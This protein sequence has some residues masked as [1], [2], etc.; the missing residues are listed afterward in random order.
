[1]NESIGPYRI[2]HPLGE[3]GMGIVYAAHDDRLDRTV[4]LKL[5]TLAAG[6][7]GRE[8]FRREAKVAAKVNHPNICQVYDV[9]EHEGQPFLAME[10]LSGQSLERRILT[11]PI[12]PLEALPLFR[13]ILQGL[14]A[15]HDAGIIH[16]DLK[17]SNVFLTAN[18]VKLLDFGLAR[19]IEIEESSL[20]KPGIVVG[21]PRYMA[22]EQWSA[23]ATGP[24]SDIFAASAIFFEMLSGR[25]AFG[26]D[27]PLA[28]AKAIATEHPP[29]LTGDPTIE[30]LD[31]VIH[32]GLSKEMADRYLS[33]PAMMAALEAASI[34][35]DE[36]LL[37]PAQVRAV[38]RLSVLPFRLLRPDEEIDF[39]SFSLADA[40]ISSLSGMRS[41]VVRSS[42][43]APGV[44][45]D[46]RPD[47]E[48]LAA[49]GD[50]DAVLYGTLLRN[51]PRVRLATQLVQVPTGTVLATSTEEGT[52]DDV[53]RL[54]DELAE[55]VV[56]S[57][58]VPLGE[59]QER[60]QRRDIPADG[61]AYQ[62]YLR[63]NETSVGTISESI[64]ETA[65]D[66]YRRCLELD[67]AFA[68]A[69]ARLGRVERLIAKYGSG[70]GEPHR[71]LA[72]EAFERALEIN[73]DLPIAHNLFTYFQIEEQADAAGAVERLLAQV[74]KV[75]DPNLYA[76]LVTAC[77]FGG[78]PDASLAADRQAR[79]LDPGISTSVT[80]T[81]FVLADFERA[82]M[83][84]LQ[85]IPFMRI[86][87]LARLGRISEGR[88]LWEAMAEHHRG[89]DSAIIEAFWK[90]IEGQPDEALAA[91]R[92]VLDS[93]FGDPEGLYFVAEGLA[94]AGHL[95]LALDVFE[96]VVDGGYYSLHLI[97]R[98]SE[99]VASLAE[100]ERYRDVLRRSEEG[101]EAARRRFQGAGG[102]EL[103]DL[104]RI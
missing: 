83:T 54:Q 87:A 59:R 43:A 47:L 48:A 68:P 89:T 5:M 60:A 3:G 69:W 9:G 27:T 46:G 96:Q 28:V 12:P 78:L 75:P 76:G 42:A 92:M 100:F 85:S 10:L 102:Y 30:A 16:R 34:Q 82:A 35:Q 36:T 98:Q 7:D 18:G 91:A 61:E 6:K 99:A 52:L 53:F 93:S 50:L 67:P 71:K 1:M 20:T 2:L 37:M 90:G 31:R 72:Q 80:Y 49:T 94:R 70:D 45:E 81:H 11:G 41:I 26:G 14:A 39:L 24:A 57:L 101:C 73:A 97:C 103:L 79:R 22:P 13:E 55:R 65:R 19:P 56:R 38:T 84:E 104:T 88:A 95:E 51:G 33:A 63:G 64:L 58:A 66:Y 4:A 44:G 40:V 15:L 86:Y 23:E 74:A 32:R 17:P 29:A 8:R 21:T 77:R 62:Y 25:P